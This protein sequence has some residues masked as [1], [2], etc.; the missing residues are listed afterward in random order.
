[1]AYEQRD[2]SGTL[3]KNDF[4]KAAKQPDYRGTA[5][6]GGVEYSIGAWIKEGNKGKFFSMSFSIKEEQQKS[7]SKSTNQPTSAQIDDEIPF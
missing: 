6:I 5:M 7:Y 2:N 3:S 1:M 4:K